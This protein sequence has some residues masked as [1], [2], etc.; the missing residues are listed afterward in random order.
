[1]PA[2]DQPRLFVLKIEQKFL[3]TQKYQSPTARHRLSLDISKC[4][5]MIPTARH[6]ISRWSLIYYYRVKYI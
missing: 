2:L 6:K 5:N 4:Q 1:M 3:P